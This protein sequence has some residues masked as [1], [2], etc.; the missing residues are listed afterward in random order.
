MNYCIEYAVLCNK[1]IVRAK[2]QDN[3]W[4]MGNFLESENEGLQEPCWG[5]VETADFPAF[6]I[7]DGMG[8]ELQGEVAAHLAAHSFHEFY[9]N[10]PKSDLK[11]FLSGACSAMNDAICS[12]A[13]SQLFGS[14]GSTAAILL[15]GKNDIYICN[16]GDSR[17]YQFNNKKLIQI[18]LDHSET[19]IASG[20]PPLTQNLGI[21][22]TEFIISPY[23]AKG[24]YE[25][26]DKYLI[27][28][29]GL[30]DMVSE[31]E[32]AEIMSTHKNLTECTEILLQKALDYGGRD[33]ITII[34]CEIRKQKRGFNLLRRNN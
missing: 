14:T 23:V 26:G 4:C 22:A 13:K 30:T 2:N 1:G 3:F 34:I 19:N 15:F 11:V 32:I 7:F 9:E 28:S 16:V 5:K 8:G 20:K 33:N 21:P 24:L 18:S 12:Y 17:V 29:D 27:C 6:A 25:I 10:N 31:G